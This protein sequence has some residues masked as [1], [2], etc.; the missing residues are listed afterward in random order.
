MVM[1]KQAPL[2]QQDFIKFYPITTRWK[3]NDIYG[4]INNV[5][6]YSYFDTIAN[7][8]LVEHKLLD[9]QS[10]SVI[11]VMVHSECFFHKSLAYPDDLLGGLAVQSIGNSSVTY[12]LGVFKKNE[13]TVAAHGYMTHVFVDRATQK[14][15]ALSDTLRMGLS[16]LL[17]STT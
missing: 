11:G 10:S 4:H 16:Q 2:T 13:Q 9:L 6:Y 15:Q 7:R 3:D 8:Y 17:T 12:R 14:P 1:A 5:E